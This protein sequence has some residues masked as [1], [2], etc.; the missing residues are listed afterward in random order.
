MEGKPENRMQEVSA[1]Q[2]GRQIQAYVFYCGISPTGSNSTKGAHLQN[3]YN[4]K[5]NVTITCMWRT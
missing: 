1:G 5:R 4:L 2:I 3:S